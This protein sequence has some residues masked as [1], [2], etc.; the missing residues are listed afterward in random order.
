MAESENQ[1]D[2]FNDLKQGVLKYQEECLEREGDS[3]RG[4]DWKSYEAQQ[5]FFRVIHSM[6][7]RQTSSILDVGCGLAHFFDFLKEEGHAGSYTGIDIS[8]TLIEKAR[9]RLPGV[10]LRVCDLLKEQPAVPEAYDFVIASGVFTLK[11]ETPVPRFE[12][13]IQSL[14]SRMFELCRV[15]VIFNMLTSYVDYQVD[16]LYYADPATYFRFAK[17]LTPYVSLKHDYPSYLFTMA[18]YK[19]GNNYR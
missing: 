9:Q 17:S 18:L 7:V 10:D 5:L 1:Q 12:E 4:V 8:A 6:G 14:I 3:A 15:G 2:Q 16:R 11:L 13:F 19:E